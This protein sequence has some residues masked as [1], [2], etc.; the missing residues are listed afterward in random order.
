LVEQK[1]SKLKKLR[2]QLSYMGVRNFMI[3]TALFLRY[4]NSVEKKKKNE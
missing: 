3:H 2:S 4:L 1:N